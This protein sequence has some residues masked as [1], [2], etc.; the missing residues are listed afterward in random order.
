M[1]RLRVTGPIR[2]LRS[3]W[4]YVGV[5]VIGGALVLGLAVAGPA[6]APVALAVGL[7]MVVSPLAISAALWVLLRDRER[8]GSAS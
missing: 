5:L 1:S 8:N 3:H 2:P 7:A 4:G 6:R